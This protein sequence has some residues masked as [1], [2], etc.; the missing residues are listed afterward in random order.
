[1]DQK[2]DGAYEMNL[3]QGDVHQVVL[4]ILPEALHP[5]VE[6]LRRRIDGATGS[7][8]ALRLLD[9]RCRGPAELLFESGEPG[10]RPSF[11]GWT[12]IRRLV[13]EV[14]EVVGFATGEEVAPGQVVLSQGR[15][16]GGRLFRILDLPGRVD[17]PPRIEIELVSDASEPAIMS[18][19]PSNWGE[20]AWRSLVECFETAVERLKTVPR[21]IPGAG[22]SFGAGDVLSWLDEVRALELDDAV[23]R[24]IERRRASTLDYQEAS[25]DVGF[26][27][28]MTLIGCALIW[29]IP[30]LLLI[31]A[32]FPQLAWLI[33]P[34][35]FGFLGLQ[36]LRWLV[37]AAPR[38][39]D[40]NR[41]DGASER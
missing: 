4:P 27:G 13:G 11:P 17:E 7:G 35:L 41:R 31:S 23:R 40:G 9:V 15:S 25:E 32:A 5:A 3:L 26:K 37:P 34:V 21:A 19:D 6:D 33:V 29:L 24:S 12:L 30:V 2:P 20:A 28:T 39:S 8:P 10:S 14:E 22:P 1:V 38:S 36:L 18:F 16:T